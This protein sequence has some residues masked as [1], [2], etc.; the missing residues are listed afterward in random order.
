[1]IRQR[2]WPMI[3]WLKRAVLQP[4]DELDRWQ[5]VGREA[6]GLLKPQS[7]PIHFGGSQAVGIDVT[8][9]RSG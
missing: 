7:A 4:R 1:M 5:A 2:L 6:G 3:H 8:T 9:E